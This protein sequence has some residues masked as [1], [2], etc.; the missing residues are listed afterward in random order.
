M[1]SRANS[2]PLEGDLT[3]GMDSER[4]ISVTRNTF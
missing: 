1:D 4:E 2:Q 3:G